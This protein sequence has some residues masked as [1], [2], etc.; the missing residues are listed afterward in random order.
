M[1]TTQEMSD[2]RFKFSEMY[3][4]HRGLDLTTMKAVLDG[5]K[6]LVHTGQTQFVIF[7]KKDTEPGGKLDKMNEAIKKTNKLNR[8][9]KKQAH[10]E[11]MLHNP[12]LA[13]IMNILNEV[14]KSL[15]KM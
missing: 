1:M 14:N 10:R 15:K 8:D 12:G 7:D 9:M 4:N 11:M 13:E 3:P 5:T 2:I 6:V